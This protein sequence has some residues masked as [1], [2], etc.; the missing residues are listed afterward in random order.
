MLKVEISNRRYDD[1]Y[2]ILNLAGTDMRV[3]TLPDMFAH[4]LCALGERSSPRDIFDCWF[5]LEHHTT[6]NEQIVNARTGK[7]VSEYSL[8]CSKLIRNV[9][10]R[11]LM[12]GLGEVIDDNMK[13]FVRTRLLDETAS[14]LEIFASFPLM[15]KY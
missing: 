7:S 11:I 12:Q 14:N 4:K 5:F 10:P 9:S 3:M 8:Y 15:E 2:E 6:I 13:R 1:H